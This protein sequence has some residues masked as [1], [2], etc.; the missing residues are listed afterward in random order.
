[1]K[2]PKSCQHLQAE[3]IN[4]E[5]EFQNL[6]SVCVDF[7]NQPEKAPI[8][9]N[10]EK[11]S[12]DVKLLHQ[13]LKHQVE[14]G[15]ILEKLTQDFEDNVKTQL[16]FNTIIKNP[17]QPGAYQYIADYDG[18]NEAGG[19]GQ[20]LRNKVYMMP[21]LEE[22]LDLMNPKE[23]QQYRQMLKKNLEPKLQ[24]TPLAYNIDTLTKKIDDKNGKISVLNR[25]TTFENEIH[26]NEFLYDFE[27]LRSTDNGRKL[28]VTGGKSKS[29]F[30]QE[31]NGWL[32][33]IIPMK[34]NI[35]PEID[36]EKELTGR[37]RTHGERAEL[38]F[39]ELQSHGEVSLNFESYLIAKMN[40]LNVSSSGNSP[41]PKE[42]ESKS[43]TMLLGSLPADN[44]SISCSY[45]ENGKTCLS[46]D[47]IGGVG[48]GYRTCR[49]SIRIKSQLLP[50]A[51][52]PNPLNISPKMC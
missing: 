20:D 23:T 6:I 12:I 32:I 18:T 31:N 34:E 4:F 50:R 30:I 24:I 8:I 5:F 33:E 44:Q 51:A 13:E 40:S 43:L 7:Q 38:Y 46:L 22:V 10:L 15:D 25:E 45:Q 35:A 14:F 36:K 17:E 26:G 47:E 49:R 52:L 48:Q 3:I 27:T 1:M 37:F 28:T 41:R 9:S 42:L 11:L 21:T 29:S 39:N 16:Y 19:K 2:K